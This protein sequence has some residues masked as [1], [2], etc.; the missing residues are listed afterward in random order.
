MKKQVNVCDV[1]GRSD[2]PDGHVTL[3]VVGDRSHLVKNHVDIRLNSI[4]ACDDCATAFVA[5]MK[6]RRG[7]P[8]PAPAAAHEPEP[9][10]A[11]P[12]TSV[13]PAMH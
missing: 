11:D 3:N 10:P 8:A 12:A 7:E 6:R 13:A 9:E 5:W 4:D 2:I 1:C